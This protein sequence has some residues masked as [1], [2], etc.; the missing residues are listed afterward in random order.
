MSKKKKSKRKKYP[1]L[2]KTDYLIAL[3]DKLHQ[4]NPTEAIILNTLKDVYSTGYTAGYLRKHDEIVRFRQKQE[5]HMNDEFNI[6][7]DEL[8]D[9]IHEKSNINQQK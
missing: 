8:D 4:I 3:A 1:H 5:K 9:L 2:L 6:F 7:K